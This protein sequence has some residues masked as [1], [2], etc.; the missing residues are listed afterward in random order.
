MRYATLVIIL[1]AFSAWN[2]WAGNNEVVDRIVAIVNDDI[3]T[4]SEVNEELARASFNNQLKVF[5]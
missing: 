1:L 3:I 4:L 5:F 2:A